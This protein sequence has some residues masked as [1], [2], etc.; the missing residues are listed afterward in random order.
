MGT[1]PHRLFVS[2]L[3]LVALPCFAL[4]HYVDVNSTNPVPPYTNWATAANVIQDAVD[5]AAAGDT[6]L[7]TNGVYSVGARAGF[8][9]LLNRVVVDRVGV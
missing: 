4:T 1:S 9:T 8:G 7:V 3:L 2:A 6:V 5:A